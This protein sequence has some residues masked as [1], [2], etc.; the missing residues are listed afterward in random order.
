MARS[1]R[2]TRTAPQTTPIVQAMTLNADLSNLASYAAIERQTLMDA[3]VEGKPN[4][5]AHVLPDTLKAVVG[6]AD[7][8]EK[9]WKILGE[10]LFAAGT[11]LAM[12]PKG[13]QYLTAASTP[14]N[15]LFY[16][17]VAVAKFGPDC[18]ALKA[19]SELTLIA[20]KTEK[21][22]QQNH[23]SAR[24][25]DMLKYLARAIQD[26]TAPAQDSVTGEEVGK[27]VGK[28]APTT[29]RAPRAGGANQAALDGSV[30][31]LLKE[32]HD[33]I[34]EQPHATKVLTALVKKI[35]AMLDKAKEVPAK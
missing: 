30:V 19:D 2:N 33:A 24:K 14:E 5:A 34:L 31:L 3:T 4:P 28:E 18:V 16:Q 9:C 22:A 10:Q 21:K 11:T 26:N 6:M 8:A 35:E 17:T 23:I 13:A 1:N 12:F 29:K 7:K 15:N 32:V 25:G 20:Q 27:E